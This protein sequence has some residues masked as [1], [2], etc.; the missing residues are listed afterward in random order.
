M[1]DDC[2]L[3]GCIACHSTVFPLQTVWDAC[4]KVWRY[5]VPW[6]SNRNWFWISY[7]VC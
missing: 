7:A 6:H 2:T 1:L 5:A 4:N 3:V